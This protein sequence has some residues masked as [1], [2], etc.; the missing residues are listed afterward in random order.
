[1]GS[2]DNLLPGTV[3][4]VESAATTVPDIELEVAKAAAAEAGTED[5]PLTPTDEATD[6]EKEDVDVDVGTDDEEVET[7]DE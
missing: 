5:A 3:V 6:V 7:D 2:T 4:S 1:M